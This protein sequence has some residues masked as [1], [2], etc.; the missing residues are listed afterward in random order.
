M[1]LVRRNF[2]DG[3][4]HFTLSQVALDDVIMVFAFAPLVALLLGLSAI[5][6]PWQ[7]L[8][9]SVAL[10]IVVSG[11]LR[12]ALRRF[13]LARA[14]TC[15]ARQYSQPAAA[16]IADRFAGELSCSCSGSKASKF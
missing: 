6:V 4:P 13:V 10:Y 8:L 5:I 12:P 15:L 11:A 2:T 9:L 14:G 3:E 7:T 16:G 1:V